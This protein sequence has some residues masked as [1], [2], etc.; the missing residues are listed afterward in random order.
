MLDRLYENIGGKIKNWA[1][2]I[3][4][5]ETLFSII[6]GLMLLYD[7][8]LDDVWWILLIIICGPLVALVSTWILYAFGELVEDVHAI[9]NNDVIHN[10]EKTKYNME[11]KSKEKYKN[12]IANN[13][14]QKRESI[15]NVKTQDDSVIEEYIEMVCPKC[16]EELSFLN[17]VENAECP[18]CGIKIDI[19]K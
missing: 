15:V 11:Q 9:R 1:Q 16:K 14:K 17:N 19:K 13:K 8:A 4:I 12:I 6:T 10:T 2:W 7:C 18:Y 5:V 3:F